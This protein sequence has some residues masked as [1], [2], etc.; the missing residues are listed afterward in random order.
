MA[1][2]YVLIARVPVA[3]IAAFRRYE[4]AVLPLLAGHGGRLARRLR[5]VAGDA[6][7]HIVEFASPGGFAA[8]RADPRRAEHAALLRAS[9]A[10]TELL[11]VEDVATG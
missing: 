8:Y 3:G 5:T 10:E 2:T 9:G 7:V 11:E 1:V 4:A 6:E